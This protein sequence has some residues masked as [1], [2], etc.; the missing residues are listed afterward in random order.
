MLV[1]LVR[2]ETQTGN[3]RELREELEG[4]ESEPVKRIGYGPIRPLLETFWHKDGDDYE[5][6]L[7]GFVASISSFGRSLCR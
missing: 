7:Y 5:M 3:Q 6:H 4:Q 2:L 1:S